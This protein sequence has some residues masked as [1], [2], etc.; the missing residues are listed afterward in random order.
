MINI[1]YPLKI[2][3]PVLYKSFTR[4]CLIDKNPLSPYNTNHD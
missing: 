2:F 3:N 4:K 1:L